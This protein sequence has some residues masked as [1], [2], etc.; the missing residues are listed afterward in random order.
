MN[1]SSILVSKYHFPVIIIS[2]KSSLE[3]WLVQGLGQ[4]RYKMNLN[5]VPEDRE[6]LKE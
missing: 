3:K 2:K 4:G 6:E 1:V 5:L